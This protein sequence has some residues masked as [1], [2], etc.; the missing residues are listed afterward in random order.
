[1]NAMLLISVGLAL[2]VGV[3]LGWMFALSRANR[4][5]TET[6][7]ISAQLGETRKQLDTA[8]SDLDKLRKE[9]ATEQTLR[10]KAESDRQ[11]ERANLEEQRNLDR[12]S[13]V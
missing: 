12:K 2:G 1:M 4:L 13:V 3:L 11:N 6:A 10:A 5:R 9:L 7:G 8:R